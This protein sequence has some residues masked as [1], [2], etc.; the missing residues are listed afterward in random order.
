MSVK[1]KIRKV[2]LISVISIIGLAVFSLPI[3]AKKITI[4]MASAYPPGHL[5]VKA[6]E[7]FAELV[8]QQSEGEIVVKIFS[9]GAM[10][11][12]RENIEMLKQGTIE[13]VT[14]GLMPLHMLAVEYSF[15]DAPYIF[16]DYEQWERAWASPIGNKAKEILLNNNIQI[17]GHYLRGFRETTANKPIYTPEDLKGVK[18]RIPQDPTWLKIWSRLGAVCTAVPLT[19]LYSSLQTGVCE[20]SEGPF[21]QI[22]SYKLQE[23]QKY[24]ILTHH[25]PSVGL[26]EINKSFLNSLDKHY[27]KIILEAGKEAA[28]YVDEELTEKVNAELIIKLQKEGMTVVIPDADAF[29]NKA[30]PIIK[31]L[32]STVWNVTTWEEILS[33]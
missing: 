30:E 33:Y 31:E 10:G 29:K 9:G 12:E 23:V 32:F 4:R 1:T 6:G 20:A 19:E 8:E 5:C 7:K 3:W 11:G 27:Q 28:R 17:L 2:V 13:M 14:S 16:P 18:M 21:P 15:F 26:I 24:L 22:Y 25:L